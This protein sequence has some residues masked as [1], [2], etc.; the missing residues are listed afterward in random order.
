MSRDIWPFGLHLD[1][2][3]RIEVSV[4]RP[5]AEAERAGK[6]PVHNWQCHAQS[7]TKDVSCTRRPDVND[8][9]RGLADQADI[10][11]AHLQIFNRN[12]VLAECARAAQRSHRRSYKSSR[13][14]FQTNLSRKTGEIRYLTFL[15]E[16]TGIVQESAESY[17]QG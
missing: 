15:R 3:F 12:G 2:Q 10:R 16:L 11:S 14:D 1:C 17:S 9:A 7:N 8:R 5:D 6:Q 13:L 4:V